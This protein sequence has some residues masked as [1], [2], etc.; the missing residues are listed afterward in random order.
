MTSAFVLNSSDRTRPPVQ[1][2]L[3]NT[4]GSWA[5]STHS[6]E[7]IVAVVE[8]LVN[9]MEAKDIYLRG[10]STRVASLAAAMSDELRLPTD[11]V[12]LVQIAGRLHDVG[13]IGTREAVLHKTTPLTPGEI[14]HI[15][16]HVRIGME[17]LAPLT[18]FGDALTFIEQH[19]ERLDGSGY[20]YG[21]RGASISDGGRVLAVAD[22]FDAICSFRPYRQAMSEDEAL[23]ALGQQAGTAF[24]GRVLDALER[25]LDRRRARTRPPMWRTTQRT[26]PLGRGSSVTPLEST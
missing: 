15:Q 18:E 13:K 6:E 24:D 19:H 20:P 17:I 23:V 16:E 25:V 12:R 2:S 4:A 10:H 8:A 14:A 1:Q 11:R 21:L 3:A 7:L 26:A 9:S 5:G 22:A